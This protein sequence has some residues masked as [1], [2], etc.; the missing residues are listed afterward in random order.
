MLR[1]LSF[2]Y[3]SKADAFGDSN[4]PG[5]FRKLSDDAEPPTPRPPQ[6]AAPT[7]TLGETPRAAPTFLTPFASSTPKQSSS[8]G[9]HPPLSRTASAASA[10]VGPEGV[11]KRP[12]PGAAASVSRSKSAVAA[13][14]R[15]APSAAPRGEMRYQEG[16]GA[17]VVV[18]Q[19]G[20]GAENEAPLSCAALLSGAHTGVATRALAD[21]SEHADHRHSPDACSLALSGTEVDVDLC[22]GSG[23]LSAC[24]S[25]AGTSSSLGAG[26]SAAGLGLE[27]RLQAGGGSSGG[28]GGGSAGGSAAG[29]SQPRTPMGSTTQLIQGKARPQSTVSPAPAPA[30]VTLSCDLVFSAVFPRSYVTPSC[31]FAFLE[32]RG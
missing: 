25:V 4:G 28:G 7:A 9:V 32:R 21:H 12:R 11:A 27:L 17:T 1:V 30:P 29:W 15:V 26:A 31:I 18:V 24:S 20:G 16:V 2:S 8:N 23:G 5:V 3:K 6:R 22:G 19:S 14:R 10:V 13:P